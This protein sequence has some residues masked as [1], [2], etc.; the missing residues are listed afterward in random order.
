M[1][2]ENQHQSEPLPKT[3]PEEPELST[4]ITKITSEFEKLLTAGAHQQPKEDTLFPLTV[5]FTVDHSQDHEVSTM[6]YPEINQ[7][8]AFTCYRHKLIMYI[9]L[10]LIDSGH[11]AN[12]LKLSPDNETC[13]ADIV[14]IP[15][16]VTS[17]HMILQLCNNLENLG[18]VDLPPPVPDFIPCCKEHFDES[19]IYQHE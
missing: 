7:E 5:T 1:T 19:W 4:V 9:Q 13:W 8:D 10:M 15:K 17:T 12:Q 11:W 2:E 3:A 18:L 6:H 14:E 16:D